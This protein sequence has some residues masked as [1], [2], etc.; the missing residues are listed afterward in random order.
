MSTSKKIDDFKVARRYARL[1]RERGEFQDGTR[2][3]IV[4]YSIDFLLLHMTDDFVLNGYG[5]FPLDTIKEVR[6]NKHDKF[7]DKVMKAEGQKEMV[8]IPY[9]IDLSTWETIF[10]SIKTARLTVTIECEEPQLDYFCIGTIHRIGTKAVSTRY[11]SPDGIIEG[12]S[13]KTDYV[14][15]T[16]VTFDDRY[17]N[18][19]TKYVRP[20]RRN[21]VDH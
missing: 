18:I 20:E 2:G 1:T 21:E 6:S 8:G 11:F 14:N 5:I 3:Y 16:K 7:Y 15:I 10:R 4:D 13:T 19:L 9:K 12:K 17:A